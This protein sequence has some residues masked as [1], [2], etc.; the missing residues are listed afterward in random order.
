MKF[1]FDGDLYKL[2]ISFIPADR[3]VSGLRETWATLSR[4]NKT[5]TDTGYVTVG[6]ALCSAKDRFVKEKGRKLSIAR[7]FESW[8]LHWYH[9]PSKKLREVFWRWYLH[10]PQFKDETMILDLDKYND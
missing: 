9:S 5:M 2:T 10:Y 8:N 6:V 4:Y 3:S 7:M 1:K